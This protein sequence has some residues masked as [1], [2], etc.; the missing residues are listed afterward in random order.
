VYS[1]SESQRNRLVFDCG[2]LHLLEVLGD[3]LTFPVLINETHRKML[4]P[5]K[6]KM[7]AYQYIW[8]NVFQKRAVHTSEPYTPKH[9]N[10]CGFSGS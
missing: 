3:P 8:I 2:F 1:Q 5:L 6:K 4:G 10:K 9:L 7:S